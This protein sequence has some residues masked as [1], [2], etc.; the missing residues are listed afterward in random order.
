MPYTSTK[1]LSCKYDLI[2]SNTKI[3]REKI[4]DVY[5]EQRTMKENLEV[6]RYKITNSVT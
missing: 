2:E 6:N 3:R 4:S 1:Q 5:I